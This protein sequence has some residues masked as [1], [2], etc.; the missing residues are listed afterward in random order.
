M[1]ALVPIPTYDRLVLPPVPNPDEVA[2]VMIGNRIWQDW[3]SVSVTHRCEAWPLFQFTAVER[4]GAYQIRPFDEC[5][6]YLGGV[7]AVTGVITVRQ[8]GYDANKHGI[9][10]QGKGVTSYA[11]ESS[12]VDDTGNHDG[13]SFEEVAQKI[14]KPFG[15]GIKTIGE[16]DGTPFARLQIEPGEKCWDCLER[17]A[18]PRGIVLGSDHLGNFLLIGPHKSTVI[19]SLVEGVNIE[20]MQAVVS[21]EGVKSEYLLRAQ[22]P[23]SDDHNGADANQQ[24]AKVPG[25]ARR[26]SPLLTTAEQPVWS[27]AEVQAR[28]SNESIW[29]EGAVSVAN[30]GVQGWLRGPRELWRIV[31]DVHV[32]S[33][34]AMLDEVMSIQTATFTQENGAGTT[35]T[36]ECVPTF[37]LRSNSDYGGLGRLPSAAQ[38]PG[39][40]A[41]TAKPALPMTSVP[42]PPPLL[43]PIS[44]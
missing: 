10:I 18:R 21:I 23:A 16:L 20:T 31:S 25:T 8:V 4:S 41:E 5:A 32:R 6:I 43:L 2:T 15:V 7:L 22:S 27:Q 38:D 24:E 13:E 44:V 17:L 9:Q 19:A 3:T 26:Y 30:I 12:I 37:L 11:A 14:L 1:N 36:L 40:Y 28:A 39:V 35:T 42:E 33:P 29:H 34:M